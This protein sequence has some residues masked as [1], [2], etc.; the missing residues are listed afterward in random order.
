MP[1]YALAHTEAF[2]LAHAYTRTRKHTQTYV[3]TMWKITEEKIV[4][5]KPDPPEAT[6][7]ARKRTS[8]EYT[9]EPKISWYSWNQTVKMQPERKFRSVTLLNMEVRHGLLRTVS[10]ILRRISSRGNILRW[11]EGPN[12]MLDGKL[13]WLVL[14]QNSPPLVCAVVSSCYINTD[15]I[16]S[17]CGPLESGFQNKRTRES[18]D[19]FQRWSEKH[20]LTDL[21]A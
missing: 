20:H 6:K 4:S 21:D 3:Y 14:V 12:T 7:A 5:A 17:F 18:V 9:Y 2:K 15:L 19:S 1:A 11:N 13:H 10:E 8:T 16:L